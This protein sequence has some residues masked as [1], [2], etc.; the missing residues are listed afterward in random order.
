VA[1]SP[2]SLAVR[3]IGVATTVLRFGESGA[4]VLLLRRTQAPFAGLW[5]QIT[6]R[7][8]A[9]ET[10]AQAA[11]REI[12]EE[13][14][15]VPDAFY[16]ADFCDQFYN[17]EENCID[18]IPIFAAIVDDTESLQINPESSEYRWA[19]IDEAIEIVPFVGQRSSLRHIKTDFVER[20]PP[21]WRRII[22]DR[23]H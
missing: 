23:A 21:E 4:K 1:P 10:A 3:S 12:R 19:T 7:I 9:G 17:A 11:A 14:G 2:G 18:L 22:L 6:G 20:D 15:P 13:T 16:S 5:C 8:E